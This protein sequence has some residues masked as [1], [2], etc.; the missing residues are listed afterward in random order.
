[1]TRSGALEHPLGSLERA[2]GTRPRAEPIEVPEQP[3]WPGAGAEQ[4]GKLGDE[5]PVESNRVVVSSRSSAGT[6]PGGERSRCASA[7]GPVE[8]TA[9]AS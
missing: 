7:S 3:R 2:P 6:R 4:A 5:Q 8:A 1:M 9:T